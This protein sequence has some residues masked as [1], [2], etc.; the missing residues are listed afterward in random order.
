M[1]IVFLVTFADARDLHHDWA[2]QTAGRLSG[3]A[4]TCETVLTVQ[5]NKEQVPDKQSK[6]TE[7]ARGLPKRGSANRT[8]SSLWCK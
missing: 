8:D 1:V 4:L 3:T 5:A 7:A 2:L 6:A